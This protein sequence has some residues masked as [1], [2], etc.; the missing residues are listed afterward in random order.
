[1]ALEGILHKIKCFTG[2]HDVP[3]TGFVPPSPPHLVLH[4]VYQ[5]FWRTVCL[6]KISDGLNNGTESITIFCWQL[7]FPHHPLCDSAGS[8]LTYS[9]KKNNLHIFDYVIIFIIILKK[10]LHPT[11]EKR[12]SP[13]KKSVT[14]HKR[15]A[16]HPTKEKSSSEI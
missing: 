2:I 3:L 16:L 5:S 8:I 11:K 12:Y 14:P 9:H 1:M 4:E 13:Q 15:K 7:L 10:V 6:W